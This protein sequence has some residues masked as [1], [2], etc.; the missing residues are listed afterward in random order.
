[1][2]RKISALVA[3]VLLPWTAAAQLPLRDIPAETPDCVGL[4][5]ADLHFPGGHQAF[6]SL[7]AQISRMQSS[8]EGNIRIWHIGGSHVQGSYFPDRLRSNFADIQ[9]NTKGEYGFAVP[10]RMMSPAYDKERFFTVTGDWDAS[11]ASRSYKGMRP[12][13]GITG[14]GARTS[15]TDASV[16]FSFKAKGD[17][18]RVAN[19]AHILGYGSDE[20]VYPY[21]IWGADTLS[22][23][24]TEDGFTVSLPEYT[25]SLRI[26]FHIPKG[27]SFI[28]NGIE[29]L[30]GKPGFSYYTSGIN[31]ASLP[32]WLEK[33]G[34]FGRDIPLASPDLMILGLGIND[35]ACKQVNFNVEVF[36]NR[37]RRLIAMV[38]EVSPS[39]RFLFITNNDSYRYAGRGMT[40]NYNGPTVEKAMFELAAEVNGAVWDLYD[41]MGGKD[42]VT[43]WRNAGLVGKDRLHFTRT[44]YELLGDLLYNAIAGDYNS[45]LAPKEEEQ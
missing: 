27:G 34:D 18:T 24:R 37:Y 17:S 6:D 28:L 3:A 30:S 25:D 19:G 13:Y 43:R 41:I 15:S 8:G 14:F 22:C 2:N 39:C 35:S 29:P 38:R 23:G 5:R 31:G 1:M 36:K 16:A 45:S 7:Y 42:S 40:Y 10:F 21:V 44:G 4:D 12:R 20:S 33:C 11:I 32:S 26:D 9:E